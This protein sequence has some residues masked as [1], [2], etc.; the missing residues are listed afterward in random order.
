MILFDTETVSRV[1]W[2]AFCKRSI[3]LAVADLRYDSSSQAK[4][5]YSLSLGGFGM[6]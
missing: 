1:E 4:I 3:L 6:D 2:I 5:L